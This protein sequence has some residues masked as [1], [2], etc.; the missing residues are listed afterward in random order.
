MSMTMEWLLSSSFG[1][2]A[3]VFLHHIQKKIHLKNCLA[4]IET[5]EGF[6]LSI[7][8]A[9]RLQ[10]ESNEY[11]FK[12]GGSGV[13]RSCTD[14]GAG[15]MFN[16]LVANL[17]VMVGV[18]ISMM[19]VLPDT[20]GSFTCLLI[21]IVITV[22]FSALHVRFHYWDA[23]R[24]V[25][26]L[27]FTT[28]RKVR[29]LGVFQCNP[30]TTS[31]NIRARIRED[32]SLTNSLKRQET[33]RKEMLE[34]LNLHSKIMWGTNSRK[35]SEAVHWYQNQVWDIDSKLAEA[36]E[37]SLRISEARVYAM[38]SEMGYT[39]FSNELPEGVN[40]C[41]QA[42][43]IPVQSTPAEP[44]PKP[45][46]KQEP[47]PYHI[48][49]MKDITLNEVLPE[50]I[51]ERAEHFVREHEEKEKQRTIQAEIDNALLA[52]RT[53]ERFYDESKMI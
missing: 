46:R 13:Y 35:S 20:Y 19:A 11:Q 27:I 26:A 2:L 39:F 36:Y 43:L 8:T 16:L 28:P 29:H 4:L 44:K 32:E 31:D 1:L 18:F 30:Y 6:Q 34:N 40:L 9:Y 37:Y 10:K 22:I 25:K 42:T 17:L 48:E 33:T 7:V 3:I 23:E 52:I 15:L 24:E 45:K 38:E 5:K 12:F 50:H 53:V 47:T 51:K 41:N 21:S 14:E 49:V